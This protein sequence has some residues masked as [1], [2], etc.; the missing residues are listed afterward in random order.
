MKRKL[1]GIGQNQMKASLVVAF[2]IA[3]TL[4][5][6]DSF[7]TKPIILIDVVA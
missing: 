2:S 6:T 4:L 7:V 1:S 3:E 5:V